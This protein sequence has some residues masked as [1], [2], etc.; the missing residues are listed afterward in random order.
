M[1][2]E[3]QKD[4]GWL[5]RRRREMQP[6][7]DHFAA[8]L[9]RVAVIMPVPKRIYH[10][11]T[12]EWEIVYDTGWQQLIDKIKKEKDECLQREFPEFFQTST[13]K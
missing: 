12:G 4:D 8:K 11:E 9:Y 1:D 6:Y 13:K 3:L 5:E 2:N 10:F 7:L